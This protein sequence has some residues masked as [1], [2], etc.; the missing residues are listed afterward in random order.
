M[1]RKLKR[2]RKQKHSAWS[3]LRRGRFA[4]LSQVFSTVFLLSFSL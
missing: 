3:N 2:K 1:K 4:P